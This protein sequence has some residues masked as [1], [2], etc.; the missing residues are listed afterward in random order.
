MS[1]HDSDKYMPSLTYTSALRAAS[2]VRKYGIEKYGSAEDWL[3]TEPIRH[4]DAAIRHI[5]AHMDGEERDPGSSFLHLAHAL[6]NI[7]FEIERLYRV[8][9]VK[10]FE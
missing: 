3:T 10:I 6:T 9:D 5:R 1:K 8:K 2:Q 4:L 7:M